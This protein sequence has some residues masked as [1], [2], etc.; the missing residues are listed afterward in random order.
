MRSI[1][2]TKQAEKFLRKLPKKQARQIAEKI[3]ALLA[4]PLS[5]DAKQLHGVFLMRVDIAEYRIVYA[6]TETQ[7]DVYVIGKRNDSEVYKILDRRVR[8]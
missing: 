8:G 5:N 1:V 4:D 2:F 3:Q 6:Y 7:I